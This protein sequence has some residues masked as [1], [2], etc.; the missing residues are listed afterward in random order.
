MELPV[1]RFLDG[2]YRV[3]GAGAVVCL[4]MIV[5]FAMAQILARPFGLVAPSADEFAGFSM[6]GATFLGMAHT[7]RNGSH[8][9]MH[10]LLSV[11]GP[12]KL[13]IFELGCTL[14][15]GIVTGLLSIYTADMMIMS[16]RIGEWT[17]GLLPIP[18]WVPMSFM[19]VG[20]AVFSVA[21]FDD[22]FRVLRGNNPSYHSPA[23]N[24]Q[25][26]IG[27]E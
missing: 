20:L 27:S 15:A 13:R 12:A 8:V 25:P 14:V 1:R 3:S 10:V 22:F 6:A 19:L 23:E 4:V 5:V 16:A 26:E 2:L 17:L 9:R 11:L 21:L 7:L 18:K 24:Q